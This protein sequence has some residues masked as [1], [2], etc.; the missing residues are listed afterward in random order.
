MEAGPLS[1]SVPP[2][3]PTNHSSVFRDVAWVLALVA[4]LAML[5]VMTRHPIVRSTHGKLPA[6][7]ESFSDQLPR[8][9]S[10]EYDAPSDDERTLMSAVVKAIEE[11]RLDDAGL[12]SAPLGY[13]VVRYRTR[14]R[15]TAISSSSPSAE[16]LTHSGLAVGVCSSS[17]RVPRTLP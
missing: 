10:G 3:T 14:M 2:P 1:T 9:G 17:P 4:I 11:G 7:I 8:A 6:L 5:W 16:H 12:L 13:E 15:R